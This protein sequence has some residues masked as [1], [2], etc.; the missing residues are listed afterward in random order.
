MTRPPRNARPQPTRAETLDVRLAA[1]AEGDGEAFRLLYG[2]LLPY[3]EA[4]V[5]G[6]LRDRAQAEEVS[7]E[8]MI[9]LWL[10][11]GRYRAAVGG[12]RPW[13]ATIARRR[14]IDRVRRL[15]VQRQ[16][17]QQ[18]AAEKQRLERQE[19]AAA[20]GA[21]QRDHDAVARA[22]GTLTALQFEAVHLAFHDGL[23]YPQ[24]AARLGI[25]VGTAKTRVRD[26]LV[27]LR[28]ELTVGTALPPAR[29]GSPRGH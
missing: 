9:E 22:L 25:P 1:A 16:S 20:L 15:G 23:S 7:Q 5:V 21:D 10:H 28:R 29:T 17:E 14:A 2:E 27:R 24:V 4:V 18:W 12:V 6:V 8:V 26:A 11:A 13:V 19:A 3:V